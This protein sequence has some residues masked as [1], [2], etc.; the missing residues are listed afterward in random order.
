MSVN[1]TK[2]IE[3][4]FSLQRSSWLLEATEPF[5]T[6][7]VIPRYVFFSGSEFRMARRIGG[8]RHLGAGNPEGRGLSG[9]R[10]ASAEGRAE[11]AFWFRAGGLFHGPQDSADLRLSSSL[12][13]QT[14]KKNVFHP[15]A[16]KGEMDPQVVLVL[17]YT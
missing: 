8:C 14:K 10:S 3:L 6:R 17:L 9:S 2:H 15:K 13:S 16:L 4:R 5:V 7:D 12:A 1:N 11:E